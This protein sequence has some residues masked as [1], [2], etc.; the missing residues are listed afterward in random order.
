MDG[1]HG[2]KRAC[3]FLSLLLL[4]F[5]VCENRFKISPKQNP[6]PVSRPIY[7]VVIKIINVGS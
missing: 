4:D 3:E 5:Y 6:T 1:G 7:F 2:W